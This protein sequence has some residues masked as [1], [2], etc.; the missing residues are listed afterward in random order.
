MT[1][2]EIGGVDQVGRTDGLVSKPEVRDGNTARLLGVI[3]EICL[4]VLVGGLTYDLD[5]VLV[6][7][8]GTV[9]TESV[10]LGGSGAPVSDVDLGKQGKRPEGPIFL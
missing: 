5:G 4:A 1:R 7:I 9:G 6:G 2:H 3:G 8:Y 10:E